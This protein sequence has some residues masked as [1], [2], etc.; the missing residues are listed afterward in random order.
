[1]K[2]KYFRIIVALI[3]VAM[4]VIIAVGH[5]TGAID[6]YF[7]IGCLVAGTIL[8]ILHILSLSKKKPLTFGQVFLD[9]ALITIGISLL[10]TKYVSFGM[11]NNLIVLLILGLGIAL[12]VFGLLT[13]TLA[14][15]RTYGVLQMILGLAIVVLTIVA[16]NVKDFRD[17]FWIVVGIVIAAYGILELIHILSN[18]K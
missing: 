14:N 7:G 13:I 15:K 11:L 10:F 1:M 3:L 9:T 5:G 8:V 17:T 18:K 2:D 16:L 12:M 6:T 4:G